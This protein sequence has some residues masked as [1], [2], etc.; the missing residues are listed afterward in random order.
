LVHGT[1]LTLSILRKIV[2]VVKRPTGQ[3]RRLLVSGARS[4]GRV[5]ESRTVSAGEPERALERW[6]RQHRRRRH[7]VADPVEAVPAAPDLG[8]DLLG[9]AEE[10]VH[11]RWVELRPRAAS[12]LVPGGLERDGA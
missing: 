8:E 7:V 2:R 12:D 4:E 10:R 5:A 6:N 3:V 1:D 11:H 9:N